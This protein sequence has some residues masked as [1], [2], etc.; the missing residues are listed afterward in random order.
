MKNKQTPKYCFVLLLSITLILATILIS[1]MA[2]RSDHQKTEAKLKVVTSFVPMYT[3]AL[4][5]LDGV[6]Q[7]VCMIM[8]RHRRTL[9]L[10]PEVIFLLSTVAVWKSFWIRLQR[11][12]QS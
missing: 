4:N 10:Y 12:I 11:R 1:Y 2:Y 5:L 8:S 7:A 9:R 6:D 3:I